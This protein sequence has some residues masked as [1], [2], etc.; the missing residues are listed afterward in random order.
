MIFPSEE[1]NTKNIT[2]TTMRSVVVRKYLFS[3]FCLF[4]HEV[5]LRFLKRIK[6]MANIVMELTSKSPSEGKISELANIDGLNRGKE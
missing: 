4:N 3:L 1:L 6:D 2:R 5:T